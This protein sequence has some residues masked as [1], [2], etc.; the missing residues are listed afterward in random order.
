M[1]LAEPPRTQR[2]RVGCAPHTFDASGRIKGEG[3]G[4][5][6]ALQTQWRGEIGLLENSPCWMAKETWVT[7]CGPDRLGK[8][9]P[10]SNTAAHWIPQS[11]AFLRLV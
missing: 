2:R 9:T 8:G 4:M 7:G 3:E 11:I 10:A 5:G 1:F 6:N